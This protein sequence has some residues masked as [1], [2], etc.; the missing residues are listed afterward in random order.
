MTKIKPLKHNSLVYFQKH[1][2]D[3]RDWKHKSLHVLSKKY[4]TERIVDKLNE[5][6]KLLNSL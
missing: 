5:V 2:R 1:Y 4:G 6:I 3:A